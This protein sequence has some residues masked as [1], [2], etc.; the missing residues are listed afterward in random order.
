MRYSFAEAGRLLD[1][2]ERAVSAMVKSIGIHV[3]DHPTNHKAKAIDDHGLETLRR[4][5]RPLISA[6]S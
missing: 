4:R 3:Y 6:A 2:D 1:I 5:L